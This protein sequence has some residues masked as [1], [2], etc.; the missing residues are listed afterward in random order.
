MSVRVRF[1]PSPTGYLHIGGARTAL[2]NWLFARKH[3][4]TFILRVEDTDRTR[5]TQEALDAIYHGMEWLGLDWD[6][7]PKADGNYGPYLQTERL[8]IY[9]KH[10][11]LLL[12]EGKAYY[13][14]CTPE[15]L[16]HKRKEAEKKKEA[17]KYDQSCRTLSPDEF[18][19]MKAEGK[20]YV[21]R[22]KMPQ[23]RKIVVADMVRGDVEFN[24]D[25]LDDF[26]IMKSDGFPTYNFAAVV[27]DHL[28]EISHIIRGDDHLS[29]TPRQIVLYEAFG[30]DLPKFAHIPMILGKDKARMSKRHGATSVIVYRDMGYLPEAMLNYIARLGW[31][32]KD[33]EIF[34][35]DELIEKFSLDGVTKSPAVFDMD[36]LNWLNGQY[37]RTALPERI[38]DLCEPLLI[39]AYKTKDLEY[40]KRVVG[41]FL[42]RLVVIPDI[43][44]LTEYFFKEDFPVDPKVEEKYLKTEQAPRIL[45]ALKDRLSKLDNF[46]KDEIEKVFKGLAEEMGVKLGVV[47]HPCR[48]ALTG[49]K[50]SP[51]MYDVVE[52]LGKERVIDRL[53]RYVKA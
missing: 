31:G 29:N 42:D 14:V 33:D 39:E 6:E 40:M 19:K 17:P 51:G 26:V 22:F 46:T 34:S 53:A 10:I 38:F 36:K 15:E 52:V 13:C 44:P 45:S 18:E 4:G 25:L 5:S 7:G 16:A 12:Q 43:V 35:R 23:G 48:A 9:K 3:K 8:D 49:R 11:D 50:E 28:M 37:I 24:T 27:D 1:A 30:W 32:H 21:V 20:P 47:I 41:L 2:F